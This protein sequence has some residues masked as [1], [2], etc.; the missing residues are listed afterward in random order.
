[1]RVLTTLVALAA[2][3]LPLLASPSKSNSRPSTK[4]T[5][6]QIQKVVGGDS[7]ETALRLNGFRLISTSPSNKEWMNERDILALY[8]S[9]T[10]F[11]DLTD[12]DLDRI[13]ALAPPRRHA[14]PEKP[15]HKALVDP[16]LELVDQDNLEKWL[17][18]FTSFKT[19]YYQSPS[20]KESAE[21]LFTQ[22]NALAKQADASKLKVSVRKFEHDWSQPSIIFRLEAAGGSTEPVVVVSAHQDSTNMWNPWFGAAPGADDDGSG[23][24]TIFEALRVL[25][26]GKFT[27]SRPL[28]FHWYAA[29]E[30]GLL[31][32]QKV[33][34]DYRQRDV[35]VAGVF[36][37]DMT[38]YTPEGKTE[39][40][41]I[42][43]D[44]V[45]DELEEFVRELVKVYVK[46]V[47]IID[48]ECGYGCS[49]HA[50]WTK[51]GYPAS[52]T[53]ETSFKESSPYIHSTNDVVE[54][55]SFEHMEKFVR[56]AIAFTVE[57]S[58]AK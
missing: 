37:A 31:G 12:G 14:I 57:L 15:V 1:M 34:A 54:N 23:S 13:A 50:S 46:G 7:D 5:T 4:K 40:I 58:L 9:E 25:I 24:A 52:F 8:Q 6:L 22:L 21:W 27:P 51:A 41:G 16:L 29:E 28:E 39:V 2:L 56:V 49:D 43:T 17:T 20:G 19:R 53:F 10:R 18:K 55:I 11:I 33:V 3:A 38:G 36:H 30:A 42:A 48:T 44:N 26:D 45:D 32:S 47:K 35:D